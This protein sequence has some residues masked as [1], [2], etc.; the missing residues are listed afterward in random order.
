MAAEINAK[1]NLSAKYFCFFGCLLPKNPS[2]PISQ[3][4]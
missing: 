3:L 2:N 4:S 1:E